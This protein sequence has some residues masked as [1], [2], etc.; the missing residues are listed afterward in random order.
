MSKRFLLLLA[1]L[2]C[3][4]VPAG[5][6]EARNLLVNGGFELLDGDG[7]PSGWYT[8]AYI[9]RRDVSQ[10]SV[11]E[12][13]R[14]GSV[15]AV[16]SNLQGN[17]A[18]FAQRVKVE[19]GCTYRFSGWIRAEDIVD[20]GRGANISIEGVYVFSDSVFDSDGEWAF[21][22][23]YGKTGPEQ[24]ELT[25]FARMGGYSGESVGSAAFDDLSLEKVESV[26]AG[27]RTENWYQAPA[28]QE[29]VYA[30]GAEDAFEE[31]APFWPW[32]LVISAV[33][34]AAAFAAARWA[35]SAEEQG[36]PDL[37]Q[38]RPGSGKATFPWLLTLGLIAAGAV[39]IVLAAV[40]P[41]YEVDVKCFES[42]GS[43][44]LNVG[45]TSFYQTVS[46]CDYPPGYLY[47]MG[48]NES[49]FRVTGG[50]ISRAMAHRLI[51]MLCDLLGALL[52][53]RMAEENGC[54]RTKASVIALLVAFNPAMALNSAC[55]GQ[56]DS[57]LCLLLMLVA[58]LAIHRRWA[59][60]LPVYVL[61]ILV[62]P[63]ALMMG[64]LGL[65]AIIMEMLRTKPEKVET[66]MGERLRFSKTWKQLGLGLILSA[67]VALVIVV[68]FC[69][70]QESATWL[71]DL[72]GRTLAS[73]D[74]ATLN[75]ANLFYL[76]SGNWTPNLQTVNAGVT[77]TL[78][79]LTL[80]WG[81]YLFMHRIDCRRS[82]LEPVTAVLLIAGA[83]LVTVGLLS[84]EKGGVMLTTGNPWMVYHLEEEE[85]EAFLSNA[86][87]WYHHNSEGYVRELMEGLP[88][89]WH[90][91]IP[92]GWLCGLGA[93]LLTAA[94][95]TALLLRRRIRTG[96][97]ET[98]CTALIEPAVMLLFAAVLAGMLI[99]DTTWGTVGTLAMALA[100]AVVLPLF[101]RSGK[102]TALPL[103]GAVLFIL[104]YVFGVKMHE[105]YLFPALF[106]LGMAWALHRDR[107]LLT[108][109]IGLS[110]TVFIN[111]G[112]VLDNS[113]R[114]GAAMGHL[115]ADTFNLAWVLSLANCVLAV[116]SVWLSQRICVN[117]DAPKAM[118]GRRGA[119]LLPVR[120][121]ESDPCTPFSHQDTSKVKWGWIDLAL[122]AAVTLVYSVVTFTTLG[123]TKAPQTAWTSTNADEAV[124]ID[125]GESYENFAM[126]YYAQVS[127][128]PF[129]V[130]TSDDGVTWT[131]D[132]LYWVEMAEGQCFRWKYVVPHYFSNGEPAF[133]AASNIHGVQRMSGRYVRITSQEQ[134]KDNSPW[135]YEPL[136]LC[137]VIF[138]DAAGN[139][140]TGASVLRVENREADSVYASDAALLLDEPDSLEGE[141][142]W[143]N[144]TYF[145]EIYHAR[146]GF[147]HA[148][149]QDAYEWTHPPLGK[150]IMSWC[151]MLF[152]MTPFGWRFAGALVGVL[153]LP[154]M[155][156][157]AKQ[158][159]RRTSMGL[160]AM[161]L[162]ALDCMHF[163]Q[164]RIATIDSY[165]VLFI[166]LSYFFMLRFMQKDIVRRSLKR[167]LPDLA[168]SGFFMGCGVASKWIGVYAGVG[169]A[170]LYFWT[171]L[172]HLRIGVLCARLKRGGGE[173]T[174]D[175]Q[176]LLDDRDLPAMKRVIVLCLW[177]LLFFVAV[178]LA[179]YLATY[180]V[181][182]QARDLRSVGDF[183]RLVFDTQVNILN[184]HGTPGMGMDHPFYS[185][186]YEWPTMQTP[187]YYASPAF[188]P[189]GWRYAIYCFGNPLVWYV[190]AAGIAYAVCRFVQNHR[191]R[192]DG[193]PGAW[194]LYA[195]T[196]DVAPAFVLIGLLAQLLPWILVPRGTYIYHY[197]A[198]VPFLILGTVLLFSWVLK[199][200]PRG[201][202]WLLGGY[203]ALTLIMFVLLFPY[204]SGVLAPDG[205]MNMIRDYPWVTVTDDFTAFLTELMQAIPLF[206]HVY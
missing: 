44:F 32:L 55:W 180:V 202:W 48:F 69:I 167:V 23:M 171:C 149:G 35:Q 125:L 39:R 65:A 24:T 159:T 91:L 166:I 51:P 164:T 183:L 77:L 142:G 110:C 139:Q 95:V 111:E 152:G 5:A 36:A 181:H 131:S 197:F 126:L 134:H 127:Y 153:M 145:D 196:W 17:D 41:G 50:A 105:R 178:P 138:R 42:W 19:P 124:V 108:L 118:P 174:P 123:S 81:A 54:G 16:V 62:K 68:P 45:P 40:V 21:V 158:L 43:T 155:Y 150:I 121:H 8:D 185:P 199:R 191:Y 38:S 1:A 67:V 122:I 63:Q 162:M 52:I 192:I 11:S 172:R 132:R 102:L 83:A 114:L 203:M 79:L 26:P 70:R 2:L 144:S 186:W 92:T 27:F 168:L 103:C 94:G 161:L 86:T 97:Q 198:S 29:P 154:A 179:I 163:T 120:T 187:M 177:C 205:W 160:T 66:A 6:Q 88:S 4:I 135:I 137:E 165:P 84:A 30:A 18:R 25:V 117:G 182:Y 128:Q 56:I 60:V 176:Q 76:F 151:I 64:F 100:F 175:E 188:T 169:L 28:P 98:L 74:R 157:L 147:E 10:F 80:A 189:A 173:F 156:L 49:V 14:T 3:L 33:Y 72:Y 195:D 130:E 119:P 204:A 193:Q 37:M 12:E 140:I 61:S 9:Y 7:L 93:A 190:G 46:F 71:T 31:A 104:L 143:W 57:V 200:L 170:V 116:W 194:R 13:A 85:L 20:S 90:G 109:L 75:T 87:S 148:T 133:R 136:K 22:E 115:N 112:I 106:L 206:P 113:I 59:A 96:R 184:Y 107:R 34:A 15:A 47:V 101:I 78:L 89:T 58:Y 53:W 82:W 99:F 129:T 141:P 201:G 73:Y 146:T